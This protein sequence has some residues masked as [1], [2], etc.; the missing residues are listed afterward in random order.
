MT[1]TMTMTA[2]LSLL[3]L[4]SGSS[5]ATNLRSLQQPLTPQPFSF[6]AAFGDNMVLQHGQGGAG[7]RAA[8]Y[9]FLG[10]QCQSV[11]VDLYAATPDSQHISFSTSAAINV[12]QQPFPEDDII[13]TE[14]W[15]E[16]PCTDLGC[17][18]GVMSGSFH[19][20]DRRSFNPWN[21]RLPTWKVWLPPQP[22]GGN[23]TIVA[24]CTTQETVNGTSMPEPIS[25]V[26][27]TFGDVWYCSGQSNMQLSMNYSFHKYDTAM[28]ILHGKY[29]NIRIMAGESI[30]RVYGLDRNGGWNY[31][32][33]GS[34]DGSNPWMTAQQSVDGNNMDDSPLMLFGATCWWFAQSLVDMGITDTPIGLVNT[35]IG[36]KRIQEFT[37]N[38]TIGQC[39]NRTRAGM[40]NQE[41]N[42]WFEGNLYAQQV[43]PFVDMTVKGW[44]WYQGENNMYEVKGNSKH[45]VGY[46]CELK[47]LIQS[48]RQA[49]SETSD[50]TPP[51]APFG[52]VTLAN[53]GG[54]GGPD[55]GSMLHA[56][57]LNY[58]ALPPPL[59][60]PVDQDF[61]GGLEKVFA[62][63]AYD[64]EDEWKANNGPCFEYKCCTVTA[65]VGQYRDEIYDPAKCTNETMHGL[66]NS[67]EG[68]CS[69][70]H[71]VPY[72]MGNIHPRSKQPVGERLAKAAYNLVYGG[73][74]AVTGPTLQ[75]CS[76]LGNRDDRLEIRFNSTLM[77][78]DR[79]GEP[80]VT[81]KTNRPPRFYPAG[82]S[83]LFVQIDPS[84]FCMESH[85]FSTGGFQ[86]VRDST[87]VCP[88]WAGGSEK[89]SLQAIDQPYDQGWIEVPFALKPGTSNTIELDLSGLPERAIPTA[90][91]YAWG[92]VDCCDWSDPD[93]FVTKSCIANCPIYA[94]ESKLPANPFM[95]KI[96][97]GQCECVSPQFC[98]DNYNED[99][100]AGVH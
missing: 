72:L 13:A 98:T 87:F 76:L 61:F 3:L 57:T 65:L 34:Q 5:E 80:I 14:E 94:A 25:L 19:A 23:F 8:I 31:A 9:G 63:Q 67:P 33:Y 24:T 47:A 44:L 26:N 27:V 86:N 17:P 37:S 84:L 59:V 28:S 88:T 60:D 53:S 7:S 90:V 82:G 39:H 66:C 77:K 50:T 75:G 73:D 74:G 62:A 100:D 11:Q 89:R 2:G 81:P 21:T 18:G 71:R 99:E 29:S 85:I 38:S 43:M 51:D 6:D 41:D 95:A 58:G 35:A 79:L 91:K 42:V 83:Q 96:V 48:W 49:W 97:N 30:N 16:R 70:A 10:P 36:G 12:T 45:D 46:G 40:G 1:L 22:A 69:Q 78:G 52:I 92:M 4:F 55:M 32:K 93:M 54:E 20:S 68:A 15:G 64:L 56:Q